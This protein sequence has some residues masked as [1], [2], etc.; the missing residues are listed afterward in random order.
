MIFLN[1][2]TELIWSAASLC[3]CYFALA[4][5]PGFLGGLWKEK[6]L[7]MMHRP[8]CMNQGQI[9][10]LYQWF[11]SIPLLSKGPLHL[12]N[13]HTSGSCINSSRPRGGCWVPGSPHSL[14]GDSFIAFAEVLNFLWYLWICRQCVLSNPAVQ[15]RQ[16]VLGVRFPP[17]PTTSFPSLGQVLSE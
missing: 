9:W 7:I 13:C 16:L 5:A 3:A 17:T 14:A 15:T 4:R 6:V 12:Q 8:P 11:W 2:N 10:R 1:G